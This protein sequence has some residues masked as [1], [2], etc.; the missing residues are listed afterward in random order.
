MIVA[1]CRRCLP[2]K[3]ILSWAKERRDLEE[4]HPGHP[5]PQHQAGLFGIRPSQFRREIDVPGDPEATKARIIAQFG[6]EFV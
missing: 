3:V 6:G 4:L 2:N 5:D 1:Y